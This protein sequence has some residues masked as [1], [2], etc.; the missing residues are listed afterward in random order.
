MLQCTADKLHEQNTSLT[1]QSERSIVS[2]HWLVDCF[3]KLY[4]LTNDFLSAEHYTIILRRF[5]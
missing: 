2:S 1:S 4:G 3:Y 5:S